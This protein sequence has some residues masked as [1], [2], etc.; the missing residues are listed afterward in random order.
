MDIFDNSMSSEWVQSQ[1]CKS[2]VIAPLKLI[3]D[4]SILDFAF[5]VNTY[6]SNI[7]RTKRYRNNDKEIKTQLGNIVKLKIV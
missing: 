1:V 2:F 6:K 3:E 4:L 7:L 5:L